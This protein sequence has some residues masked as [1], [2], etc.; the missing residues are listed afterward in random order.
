MEDDDRNIE[1]FQDPQRGLIKPETPSP[2]ETLDERLEDLATDL[3]RHF[4]TIPDYK[5]LSDSK[6]PIVVKS[7]AYFCID[8]WNLIEN[9]KVAGKDAVTCVVEYLGG[10]SEC[11]EEL[12]IR[13]VALRV[14]PRG[15]VGSYAEI[16][17]NVK[18]L[19]EILLASNKD[20]RIFHHGG[21]RRGETFTNNK[22][23]NVSKVLA[24]RLGKSVKTI[25]QILNHARFLDQETL[26]FLADKEVGKDFF[27]EAQKNKRWKITN[28]TSTRAS[29]QEIKSQISTDMVSWY[30]EYVNRKEIN[31][32]W[33]TQKTD[34]KKENIDNTEP[35]QE[36]TP[37][38]MKQEVFNPWCGNKTTDEEDS[39][40]KVKDDL[41]ALAQKL[42]KIV[43]LEDSDEFY[44]SLMKEI[45]QMH[46]IS[47]RAAAFSKD[48][49]IRTD[50]EV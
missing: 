23:E 2:L 33:D 42:L 45:S 29:D 48:T 19:E 41:E 12:A 30:E 50:K 28:L 24:A 8:G 21:I 39:L 46:L 1:E 11:E 13:K 9:A 49:G 34:T 25:D 17:R 6:H 27:E 32:I 26:S 10:V 44:K 43:T 5:R 22:Q 16:I 31:P 15:G 7:T 18:S 38:E 35:L 20:L 14:R 40:Y 47:L 36:M 4:T 3:I 37:R